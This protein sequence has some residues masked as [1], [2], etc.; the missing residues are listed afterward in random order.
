MKEATKNDAGKPNLLLI[1]PVFLIQMAEV[2]AGGEAMHGEQ[3]WRGLTQARLLAA[4]KRHT[5]AIEQGQYL[6]PDTG[7][8]HAAHAAC[9]LMMFEFLIRHGGAD[10]SLP[11]APRN[12]A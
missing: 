10:G 3:N 7:K 12:P 8:P 6:D 5:N 9:D 11:F 1:D 2:L 4:V